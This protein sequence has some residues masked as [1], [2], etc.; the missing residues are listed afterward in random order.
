MR[1]TEADTIADGAAAFGRAIGHVLTMTTFTWDGMV[2]GGRAATVLAVSSIVY[3]AAFGMVAHQAGLGLIEASLMSFFIFSGTAQLA[4]VAL[5]AAGGAGIASMAAAIAVMNARY[6]IFGASLRSWLADLTPLKAYGTLFFLVDGSWLIAMKAR[7]DGERDA[8][9]L[10]G[11]SVF[12]LLGWMSGTIIGSLMGNAVI[13]PHALGI[14]FM[15]PAFAAAMMFT[16]TRRVF[17][18]GPIVVGAAAALLVVQ[19]AS[20]GWAVVAAGIAGG[21]FTGLAHKPQVRS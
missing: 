10:F 9:Y 11:A 5:I 6:L 14:D 12:M 19:F 20:F 1:L 15:L 13:A 3:G 18:V 8:G 21:V 4:A 17:D 16:M 7:A 2:R